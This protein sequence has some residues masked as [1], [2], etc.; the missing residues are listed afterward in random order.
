M[1]D[2]GHVP[3]KQ[4]HPAFQF[5]NGHS[6]IGLA[7]SALEDAQ[8]MDDE[9]LHGHIDKLAIQRESLGRRFSRSQTISMGDSPRV[10]TTMPWHVWN[11]PGSLPRPPKLDW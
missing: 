8:Y 11:C 6:I 9:V 4:G 10:S 3:I 2:D 1:T 5:G 7:R